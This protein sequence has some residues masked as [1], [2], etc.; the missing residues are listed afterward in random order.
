MRWSGTSNG[1]FTVSSFYHLL[2]RGVE[3][4]GEAWFP[5]CIVWFTGISPKVS[6]FVWSAA[7]NRILTIDNLIRRKQILVN[8]CCMCRSAA[9]SVDHLLVHC[10]VATQL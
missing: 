5:C 4:A 9:E 8:W 7:L 6:F 3:E 10:W 2:D 1:L